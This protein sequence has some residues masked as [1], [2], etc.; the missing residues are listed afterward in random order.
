MVPSKWQFP[1][2][3]NIKFLSLLRNS[4]EVV[5]YV[6]FVF[7]VVV[8]LKIVGSLDLIFG[9]SCSEYRIDFLF[10]DLID[11]LL[12]RVDGPYVVSIVCRRLVNWSILTQ[13][14]S[15]LFSLEFGQPTVVSVMLKVLFGD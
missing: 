13:N 14:K 5:R 6:V 15:L 9:F 1:A 4:C 10:F 3:Y 8:E 7:E 2:R 11:D 12:C